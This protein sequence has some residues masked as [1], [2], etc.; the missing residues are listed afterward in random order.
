MFG[1]SRGSWEDN[2][3]ST[4]FVSRENRKQYVCGGTWMGRRIELF[5][6]IENLK[7]AVEVDFANGV[8]AKWH[9]ESHLNRWAA[10][11]DFNLLDP[12]FCYVN[13]YRHLSDLEAKIIAVTKEVRTR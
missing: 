2:K 7:V 10:F 5:E 13:E 3:L 4:A 9:D 6:L 12:S 8:V 11:N 1:S